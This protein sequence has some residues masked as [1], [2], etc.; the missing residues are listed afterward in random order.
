MVLVALAC[1]LIAIWLLT[2]LHGSGLGKPVDHTNPGRPQ[3]TAAAQGRT[4][5]Y[6]PSPLQ[7]EQAG[8]PLQFERAGRF[9]KPPGNR[10]PRGA[11]RRGAVREGWE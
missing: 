3:W 4:V 11:H 10:Q 5:P 8:S 2:G 1:L 6:T 7:F 9:R